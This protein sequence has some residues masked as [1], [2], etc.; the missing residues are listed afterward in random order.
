MNISAIKPENILDVWW[1]VRGFIKSALEY[2]HGDLT[3]TE[4]LIQCLRGKFLLVLCYTDDEIKSAHTFEVID[5]PG[6][7]IMGLVTTGGIDLN[8]WQDD[9]AE[10]IDGLAASHGCDVIHTRGRI[11]WLKKL[12]RNGYKP[13]YFIAEKK[14][15]GVSDERKQG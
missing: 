2:E 5:T 11:G 8:E 1:S 15:E 10:V 6:K 3:E 12:E 14:V 13:L 9:L 4:I 7:R